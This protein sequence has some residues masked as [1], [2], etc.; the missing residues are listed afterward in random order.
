MCDNI[1]PTWTMVHLPHSLERKSFQEFLIISIIPKSL[2]INALSGVS[3]LLASLGHTGRRFVLG[4]V[5]HTL[6]HV[7]TKVSHNVLSK[8]TVLCWA[9]FVA[10]LSSMQPAGC[11]LD[12]P[13]TES[14]GYHIEQVHLSGQNTSAPVWHTFKRV[15]LRRDK[16]CIPSPVP[17]CVQLSMQF[18]E[19][20]SGPAPLPSV[21]RCCLLMPY[22]F[23]PSQI[24]S[25]LYSLFPANCYFCL[26][27]KANKI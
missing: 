4:H 1:F 16:L 7:I 17:C 21:V 22:L 25:I 2:K 9:T 8:L 27:P 6:R 20:S 10:I 13:V 15:D 14:L 3:N 19:H 18:Y 26:L 5:L 24:F 23:F 11:R 12:T